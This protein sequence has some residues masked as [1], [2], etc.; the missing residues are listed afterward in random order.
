IITAA[1]SFIDASNP[2][3]EIF[4]VHFNERV[5]FALQDP[6]SFSSDPLLLKSALYRMI[7]DGKT[8]LY[9]AISEALQHL[10]KG[11]C[12]RKALVVVSDGGDNASRR[13][14]PEVLHLVQSAHTG[15]YTLAVYDQNDKDQNPKVLRRLAKISGGESFFP[16]ELKQVESVCQTVAA[17]IRNQYL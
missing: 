7:P 9:D 14:L 16:K 17:D 11:K 6:T 2:D 13:D 1:M 10:A 5:Q 15:V 3:D 12:D 8:A 4:V